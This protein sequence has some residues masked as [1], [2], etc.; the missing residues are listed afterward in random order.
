MPFPSSTAARHDQLSPQGSGVWNT[1]VALHENSHQTYGF[2]GKDAKSRYERFV[3][4]GPRTVLGPMPVS[5]FLDNFMDRQRIMHFHPDMPASEGAFTEVFDR[6][7]SCEE[8]IYEPL[9]RVLNRETAANAQRCPGFAFLN[10]S[11][12]ADMQH[13]RKGSTKPDVCCYSKDHLDKLDLS[14]DNSKSN[15]D[16]GFAAMVIEVK[17]KAGCDFAR[18]PPESYTGRQRATWQFILNPDLYTA[19]ELDEAKR[20]FGQNMTYA[21]EIFARQH[22]HALFSVSL[23]GS[24]ARFIRWDRAGA[25]VTAAFDI[26]ESP[27]NL[28]QF[29]WCFAWLSDAGRGY[30]LTV[31]VAS[32]EEEEIFR[33]AIEKHVKL[34]LGK[35][36]GPVKY[37]IQR[38]LR[39]HYQ[40]GVVSVLVMPTVEN[41]RQPGLQSSRRILV[42]RPL[43][44]PLSLV[45][46][47]T[48]AYW[49]V[50]ADT[51]KVVFLKDTWRHH[52]S[53]TTAEG[54]EP[55]PET[56]GDILTVLH[57]AKVCNIPP[58]E[59][60]G[61]VPYAEW[62]RDDRRSEGWT[63]KFL[64]VA[65]RTRTQDYL[66]KGWVCG[67]GRLDFRI[68]KHTHYR[69]VLGVVGY[70]LLRLS[71]TQELLHSSY[72]AFRALCDAHSKAGFLHRDITPG[73]IILVRMPDGN[74]WRRAYLV[75]WEFARHAGALRTQEL[76]EISLKWQF[77]SRKVASGIPGPHTV[78]DDMESLLYTVL[79]SAILW[80]PYSLGPKDSLKDI[81]A[82][83][84]DG[85]QNIGHRTVGGFGKLINSL[86]VSHGGF[87][88]TD[89]FQWDS[90][91]FKMWLDTL[92]GYMAPSAI[93]YIPAEVHGGKWNPSQV[94][95][96]WSD[97]L[98]WKG[99]TLPANDRRKELPE[100]L[101]PDAS[102][103]VRSKPFQATIPSPTRPPTLRAKR[104]GSR[105]PERRPRLPEK[106]PRLEPSYTAVSLM[107][108]SA[109]ERRRLQ[110][111]TP[112]LRLRADTSMR[113]ATS[114]AK[115]FTGRS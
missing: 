36:K 91:D 22:R 20:A 83:I 8:D 74:P 23:S 96:F 30:D 86:Q 15:T 44:Y 49:A 90:P 2:W 69:L 72:N 76:H 33:S 111:P 50:D 40:P 98:A 109:V 24:S 65:Q 94:E 26:L 7:I 114:H 70:S 73:N 34:Q 51:R 53:S 59:H 63:L 27:E 106:R 46:R 39:D 6:E 99:D 32:A 92:L 37:A 66:A 112:P 4:E 115:R 61:D 110:F 88:E 19:E 52:P 103:T 57:G 101:R 89:K 54:G 12:K 56:E 28:C 17:A 43:S 13:G 58:M 97:F 113:T 18:D 9:L 11:T 84:F 81:M 93:P 85:Y 108:T 47:A 102:R 29:L 1:P 80:L 95:E 41:Q 16:M 79:Y 31:G 55:V 75:D 38:G 64:K 35:V 14:E 42:S 100:E 67:A 104:D 21:T 5:K 60:H 3:K 62:V 82:S 10:T 78:Q 107:L 105:S 77:T 45:G 25:V 48:R 68:F 87:R 71:G